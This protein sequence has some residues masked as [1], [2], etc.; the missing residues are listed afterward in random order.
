MQDV[1]EGTKGTHGA[2]T[3]ESIEGVPRTEGTEAEVGR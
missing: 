2:G 1:K 3:T